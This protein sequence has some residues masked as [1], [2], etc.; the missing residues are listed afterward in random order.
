MLLVSYIQQYFNT[1]ITV[2]TNQVWKLLI[3]LFKVPNTGA[4]TVTIFL[5]GVLWG[6]YL[7]MRGHIKYAVV[8]VNS[9]ARFPYT[10]SYLCLVV[11][12][13]NCLLFDSSNGATW[14]PTLQW[15]LNKNIF[16]KQKN[17]GSCPILCP[18]YYRLLF[19]GGGGWG[20]SD[21]LPPCYTPMRDIT[22]STYWIN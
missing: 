11:R 8:G 3:A 7:F 12:L 10:H 14:D 19:F 4:F 20:D 9:L 13:L 15:T 22:L 2:L 1:S 21:P 17:K 5:W 18:H 6:P 16:D